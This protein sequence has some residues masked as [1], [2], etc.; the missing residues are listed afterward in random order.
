[1]RN[2]LV[3]INTEHK[4]GKTKNNGNANLKPVKKF[5]SQPLIS[6][7]I[8]VYME[9]KILDKT[10]SVYTSEMRR[11]YNV[12]LIVSDGG[13]TDN[14]VEIAEKFAD[15][16]V[17]HKEK[18]RQTIAEGRNRGAD[19]AHGDILVF[20][21]G[22]TVPANPAFFFEFISNIKNDNCKYKSSVALAC[23]VSVAP[24]EKLFKDSVFYT[25]HNAYV[26]FLNAIGMGMGR[27]ECQIVHS[28]TFK[29]VGGY[30]SDLTAGEDFDLY[31]RIS[32]VGKISFAKDI[33]VLESPRRFRKFG[34]I[35]IVSSWIINSLSVMF[36]NRSVSKE[37]EAV[38]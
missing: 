31:R 12:E 11:K 6:V 9:E 23:T 32:K 28:D 38:R 20:I 37:W 19:V 17:I 22:D 2:S 29:K 30:N 4:N 15:K 8:P 33:T 26:R 21:N 3:N 36:L 25:V 10:L 7:I 16:I 13:S 35:R 18:R 1:M 27:G 5:F 34:Y 14:T 24:N